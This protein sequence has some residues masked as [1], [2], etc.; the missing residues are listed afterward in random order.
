VH[1]IVTT[2]LDKQ[3]KDLTLTEQCNLLGIGRSSVYY[4]PLPTSALHID[5]MNR[6]DKIHT[7]FPY[8]GSRKI[9]VTLTQET[10]IQIGRKRTRTLMEEM[11]ITAIY[12]KPNLSHSN[13]PHNKFPYRLK[14]IQIVRPNQVW[15][16]DITYIKMRTGFLYLVVF[17]D[18]YSRYILSWQLS[19]KL[20][21]EFCIEAAHN[22]LTINTPDIV[23]FD[24]G[25]QFTDKEMIQVWEYYKTQI[26]MDHKGR[27]FD[28][29]FTER[30]WRSFKYEEVYLKDYTSYADAKGSIGSY[31][32]RYNT[33]RIHQAL[34]YKT[35]VSIYFS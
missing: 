17:M 14:G 15:S 19:D 32:N 22:A 27:C 26:S 11:G 7:D 23:N 4:Q 31:I 13:N 34:S 33:L 20:K 9:A 10:G 18:W 5:L 25:V 2:H 28:N 24:Q 16:A 6:I 29:I 35:P 3:E 30:F 1:D 12:P 8:Y 21:S